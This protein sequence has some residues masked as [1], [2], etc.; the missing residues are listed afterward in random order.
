MV[1]TARA[2]GLA[3]CHALDTVES[4]ATLLKT[5]ARRGDIVLL[6]GSR[7]AGMERL[8]PHLR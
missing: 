8:L 6:K 7:A 4:A 3:S 1:E 2:R 5:L